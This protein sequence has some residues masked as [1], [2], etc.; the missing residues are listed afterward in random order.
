M[1]LS[2]I[3][4]YVVMNPYMIIENQ[5]M[6]ATVHTFFFD[7]QAKFTTKDEK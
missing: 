4:T 3:T 1:I 2:F 6:V 5:D 7:K